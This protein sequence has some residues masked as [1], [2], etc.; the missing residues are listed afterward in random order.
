MVFFSKK[1]DDDMIPCTDF[2]AWLE[3]V[4]DGCF[5][6]VSDSLLKNFCACLTDTRPGACVSATNDGG[7]VVLYRLSNGAFCR[8]IRAS[9]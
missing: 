5:T 1:A 6:G 7:A 9:A 2:L 4:G 3:K 8:K